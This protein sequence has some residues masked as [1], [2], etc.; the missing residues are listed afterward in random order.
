MTCELNVGVTLACGTGSTTSAFV[1][2]S[3]GLLD[4]VVDVHTK[5]GVL[6]ITSLKKEE[7]YDLFLKG[8]AKWVFSGEIDMKML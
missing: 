6:T 8:P 4:S 1:G 5:G 7:G 2:H 3:M